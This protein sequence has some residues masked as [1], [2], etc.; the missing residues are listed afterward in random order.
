ML[1]RLMPGLRRADE[2]RGRAQKNLTGEKLIESPAS[3]RDI[4]RI[5]REIVL[6]GML[7]DYDRE[8]RDAPF[9]KA[10]R[11]V[12]RYRVTNSLKLD[13]LVA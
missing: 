1:S 8:L 11:V 4:D 10:C 12:W 3:L 7:D 13:S 9:L 6:G 5:R 2:K